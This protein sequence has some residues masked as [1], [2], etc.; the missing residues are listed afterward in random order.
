MTSLSSSGLS[1]S[2]PDKQPRLNVSTAS[3]AF[4][5]SPTGQ[6]VEVK[7]NVSVSRKTKKSALRV[8]L[9]RVFTANWVAS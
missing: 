3:S 2:R 1:F 6:I 5:S 8:S 7:V 4:G 9:I